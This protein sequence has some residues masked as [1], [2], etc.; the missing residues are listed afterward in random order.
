MKT[1]QGAFSFACLNKSRTRDAPTQ[2][3]ISTKSEPDMEKNGTLA[4][5]ATAFAKSVLPVP[6]GPTNN[7]P[8]GILPPNSVYFE[9]FFKNETI[10]S[11]SC[12]APAKPATSLKLILISDEALLNN[13]AFY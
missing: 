12:L 1:I 2:T 7:A 6:G 9:G 5:P 3:T 8:F 13:L 4:S 11:T 10:S